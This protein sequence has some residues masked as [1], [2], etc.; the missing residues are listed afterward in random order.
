MLFP[1]HS[2]FGSLA[3]RHI[4]SLSPPYLSKIFPVRY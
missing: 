3:G 1:F 4:A 2:E